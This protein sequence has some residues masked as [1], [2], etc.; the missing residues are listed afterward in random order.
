[1]QEKRNAAEKVVRYIP[2]NILKANHVDRYY[3][4]IY[5]YLRIYV[6]YYICIFKRACSKSHSEELALGK[7]LMMY[8]SLGSETE[9]NSLLKH[10]VKR[11]SSYYFSKIHS[12]CGMCNKFIE[13][14]WRVWKTELLVGR[15][16]RLNN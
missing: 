4:Q 7:S 6:L 9:Q 3:L 2:A 15:R 5:T 14:A 12:F 10:N 1:M 11:I 8:V 16:P 13:I